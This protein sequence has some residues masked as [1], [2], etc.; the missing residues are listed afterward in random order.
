MRTL[1]TLIMSTIAL[2]SHLTMA[3]GQ[4]EILTREIRI[5]DQNGKPIQEAVADPWLINEQYFW[6][7]KQLTRRPAKSTA[8]GIAAIRYPKVGKFIASLPVESIKMTVSHAD[9]C[10]AEVV[11][12]VGA[13]HDKPYEVKL[14]QGI[15][16]ALDAVDEDGNSLSKPFAVM[17]TK[18]AAV[19]RWNRP[20]PNKANCRSMKSGNHRFMLVQPSYDGRHRFSDVLS[21]GLSWRKNPKSRWKKLNLD[22]ESQFEGKLADEVTRPVVNGTVIAVHVPLPAG[23]SWDDKLPSLRFLVQPIYRPMVHLS[24]RHCHRQAWFN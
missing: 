14:K 24:L 8:N 2:V 15:A 11:V 7:S 18:M 9:Y 22:R 20:S 21:S 16:L 10:N 13:G 1:T 4:A 23:D 3:F 6:P 19:T 17:T 5:V 12:P